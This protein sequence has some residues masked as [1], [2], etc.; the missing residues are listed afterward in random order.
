[1]SDEEKIV[2]Q[3]PTPGA[4]IRPG[5]PP[6]VEELAGREGLDPVEMLRREIDNRLALERREAALASD[7]NTLRMLRDIRRRLRSS[8]K[9]REDLQRE[10]KQQLAE[11]EREIEA[12]RQRIPPQRLKSTE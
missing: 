4:N 12:V 2:G 5:T 10:E 8:T 9:M 7:L 6:T 1:M 11:V 3:R